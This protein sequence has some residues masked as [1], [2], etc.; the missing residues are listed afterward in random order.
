MEH[1]CVR[2]LQI[3]S[4]EVA[5]AE[6]LPHHAARPV[7]TDHILCPDDATHSVIASTQPE[8][9]PVRRLPNILGECELNSSGREALQIVQQHHLEMILRHCSRPGGAE[10]C[11][12][13]PGGIADLDQG[14]RGRLRQGRRHEHAP[15]HIVPTGPELGRQSPG[16]EQLHGPEADHRRP[17]M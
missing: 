6:P 4:C 1:D 16:A 9:K 8:A 12:F 11:T 2:L 14:A 3:L 5:D 13:A 7:R 10:Q 17:G 15:L